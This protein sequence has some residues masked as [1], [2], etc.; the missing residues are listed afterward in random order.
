MKITNYKLQITNKFKIF[1]NRIYHL[2]FVIYH[3]SHSEAFTLIELL[4]VVALLGVIGVLTTQVFII[5]FRS[6]GKAEIEK[7][8]KQNGDYALSIIE[9]M[10]RNAADF[11]PDQ[12]CNKGSSTLSIVN[13]D[14]YTTIFD[15]TPP[16][17]NIASVSA[18]PTTTPGLTPTGIPLT[19]S[20][21]AVTACNFQVVCPTPPLSPKY[22][23]VDFTVTQGPVPGQPT[24]LP[25]NTASLEYSGTFSLG[26]YK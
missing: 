15:C 20:K 23:F 12:A 2:S 24:P 6:Q 3:S 5:G 4:V 9:T 17:Q 26:N 19:S 18:L 22:V 1:K 11:A 16:S 7:E 25:E 8:V 10:V 13:P 14:G 21:V